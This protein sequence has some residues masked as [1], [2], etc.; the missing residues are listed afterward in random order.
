M[1]AH[2]F[3]VSF[4]PLKGVL[5]T[6]PSRYLCTIGRQPVF[7]LGGWAPRIQTGFHVSR[8]TWDTCRLARGFRARGFHPLRRRFP[9][10]CANCLLPISGSRNPAGHARRFGLFRVR[11]PLLAESRLISSPPGTEMFHFPGY[12]LPTLWIHVGMTPYERRRI[13]PFG[14]PRING[15]LRLPV[16]YRGLPRPSSPAVA[17]AS[18]MRPNNLTVKNHSLTDRLQ[19]CCL[20]TASPTGKRRTFSSTVCFLLTVVQVVKELPERNHRLRRRTKEGG[21]GRTWTRTRGLVLIRDAL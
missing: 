12:G 4:T 18:I 17:K 6:F 13:A 14:N 10:A 2:D 5:F 11:S 16:D 1:G 19:A 8:P 21:G 15:R 20:A 3:R 7:S 9:A